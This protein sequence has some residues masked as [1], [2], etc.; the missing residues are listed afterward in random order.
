LAAL[1]K[2]ANPAADALTEAVQLHGKELSFNNY[3]DTQGALA[4]LQ[5]FDEPTVVACKHSVPCGV[6]SAGRLVDAYRKAHDADPQSI[7]GGVIALNREVN[8]ET[9][10]E[11]LKVSFLEVILA[12]D[13]AKDALDAL[14][15]KK[16]LRLLQL[17]M[18]GKKNMREV[19][20]K[21]ISG[22]I[23]VQQANLSLLPDAP[24]VLATKR[25]P[26][27]AEIADL[28][29]AWKIVKHVKSNG[30]VIA[31]DKQSLG[32]G[33]GQVSR[34]WAAQQA[35]DHAVEH[36]GADVL[37]GAALASEAL[38]PFADSIEIAVKAGITAIIQP[39]GSVRDA[40]VIAACDAAGIAMVLTGMRHFRH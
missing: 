36:L 39:G 24:I 23:L 5:E 16:N 1:Y 34:V 6:G 20:I 15:K 29:Y 31:K 9:A 22:G 18:H 3:N 2:E 12:P 13:Y 4:L 7:F 27:D 30:I 14:M 17:P 10:A 35:V 11:L 32:I 21:K 25:K 37:K 38:F 33:T 8:G 19:D 40:E 28:L 26:T